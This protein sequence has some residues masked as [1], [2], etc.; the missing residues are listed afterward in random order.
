MPQYPFMASRILNVTDAIIL[1]VIT[2]QY[3]SAAYGNFWKAYE[4]FMNDYQG[5]FRFGLSGCDAL[6]ID[7]GMRPT[8]LYILA[9]KKDREDYARFKEENPFFVYLT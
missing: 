7:R 5:K 2:G 4:Q 6:R 9:G 1:M 8:Q 3:E